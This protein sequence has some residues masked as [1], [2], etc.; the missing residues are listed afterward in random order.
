MIN[1]M[2]NV[3][4]SGTNFGVLLKR[5]ISIDTSFIIYDYLTIVIQ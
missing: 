2:R 3:I 4:L 5:K 1:K